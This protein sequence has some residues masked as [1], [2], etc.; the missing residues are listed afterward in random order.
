MDKNGIFLGHF[1]Y[2]KI[3]DS[4]LSSKQHRNFIRAKSGPGDFRNLVIKIL[5]DR[6]DVVIPI[7]SLGLGYLDIS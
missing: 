3:G 2:L 7:S 5:K 1:L 4:M 6:L